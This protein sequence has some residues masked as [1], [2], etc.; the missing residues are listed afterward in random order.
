MVGVLVVCVVVFA[1]RLY[2]NSFQDDAMVEGFGLGYAVTARV[3]SLDAMYKNPATIAFLSR[4]SSSFHYA[5]APDTM[6]ALY[7]F[8]IA[9]PT[10][11]GSFGLS[12]PCR[13]VSDIPETI[14]E[15][16]RGTQ[17]GTFSDTEAVAKVTYAIHLMPKLAVG[18][19]SAYHHH[20]LFN[21]S[22]SGFSVDVG[23]AYVNE[24]WTLGASITNVVGETTW[25]T[26]R[27]ETAIQSKHL[28]VSVQLLEST[29]LAVDGDYTSGKTGYNVGLDWKPSTYLNVLVGVKDITSEKNVRLGLNL[30]VMGAVIHY[31]MSVNGALGMMHK[32]GITVE[33]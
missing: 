10:A 22:S 3:E 17:I 28:G 25:S 6:S 31:A 29:S 33:L 24:W 18:L 15:G 5:N 8:S 16:N 1:A 20:A 23:G 2:A 4:S 9:A 32:A 27:K 30:H 14:E 21:E 12:V 11:F 19:S 7:A 13:I 26:G